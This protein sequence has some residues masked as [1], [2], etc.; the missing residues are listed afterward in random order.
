MKAKLAHSG[1]STVEYLLMVAIIVLAC[2]VLGKLIKS[3]LPMVF[4]AIG[5]NIGGGFSNEE[6]KQQE[7]SKQKGMWQ[8]L[9]DLSPG[10]SPATKTS[11]KSDCNEGG[12]NGD[13]GNYS[14]GCVHGWIVGGPNDGARCTADGPGNSSQ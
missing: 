2:I 7:T 6:A 4:S 10:G 11:S 9:K 8:K 1:Q 3:A 14:H 12:Q 5:E 13:S